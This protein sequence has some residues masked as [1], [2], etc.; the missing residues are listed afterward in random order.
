M[1]Q[2][3]QTAGSLETVTTEQQIHLFFQ[4]GMAPEQIAE[5]LSVPRE[6]V[7]LV[8]NMQKKY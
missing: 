1:E 5:K 3:D 6:K 2:A 8:L 4:D 7:T